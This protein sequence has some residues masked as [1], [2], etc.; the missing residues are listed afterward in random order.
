MHLE[1]AREAVH[2]GKPAPT[3]TLCEIAQ[4]GNPHLS[5]RVEIIRNARMEIAD[6]LQ[7]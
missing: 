3:E 4:Q 5:R 7:K 1:T 6:D 2:A